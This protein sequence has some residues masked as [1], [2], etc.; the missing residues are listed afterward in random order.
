MLHDTKI[1]SDV[2]GVK[3]KEQDAQRDPEEPTSLR[4]HAEANRAELDRIEALLAKEKPTPQLPAPQSIVSAGAE[5][6]GA[7][8]PH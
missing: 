2:L 3:A 7:W 5:G 4:E 6:Q 8:R 1:V